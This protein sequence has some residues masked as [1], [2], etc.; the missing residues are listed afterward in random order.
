MRITEFCG[1][2]AILPAPSRRKDESKLRPNEL[3]WQLCQ[4]HCPS[5]C[6]EKMNHRLPVR[7]PPS[8]HV[9]PT[10]SQWPRLCRGILSTLEAY[11]SDAA[12]ADNAFNRFRYNFRTAWPVDQLIPPFVLPP[13]WTSGPQLYIDDD[14]RHCYVPVRNGCNISSGRCH[15]NVL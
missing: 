4:F 14:E 5:D 13:H 1:R 15:H 9:V 6:F 7:D 8:F 11:G 3:Q 12:A 2:T 10:R